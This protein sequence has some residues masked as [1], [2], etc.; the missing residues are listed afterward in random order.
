MEKN[1]FADGKNERFPRRE[2]KMTDQKQEPLN[3]FF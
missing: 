2:R 1:R 3:I